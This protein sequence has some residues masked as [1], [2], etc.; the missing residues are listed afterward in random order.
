MTL[1]NRLFRKLIL[2]LFIPLQIIQLLSKIFFCKIIFFYK[3]PKEEII[4]QIESSIYRVPSEQADNIRT[5]I[6]CKAKPSSSNIITQERHSPR[7]EQGHGYYRTSN[8]QRQHYSSHE[9]IRLQKKDEDSPPG[10][11]IHKT[12]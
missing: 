12:Q 9:H 1:K 6:L 5:Q 7:S 4:S 8:R 2:L 11:G 3:I 10:Q